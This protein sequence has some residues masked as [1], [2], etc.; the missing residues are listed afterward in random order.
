MFTRSNKA[1]LPL[2]AKLGYGTIGLANI[3]NSMIGTW[4]LFFFTTFAGMDVALAGMTVAGGQIAAALV[5]PAWGYLSDRLY[6]MRIGRAIGRR[7]AT[8]L[9]TAP[10]LFAFSIL[11]FAHGL[12]VGVYIASNFLYW[13]F[14]AGFTTVQYIMPSEMTGDLG[15][16]AQLVGINQIA[17]AIAAIT[18]S[19]VNTFLF[20]VWGDTRWDTYFRLSVVYGFAMLAIMVVGLFTIR[21]RP[22]DSMTDFSDVDATDNVAGGSQGRPGLIERAKLMAWNY[23]SAFSVREFRRY[24]G[25]YL[26]QF[27][28]RTIRGSTLTY[29]LV[30]VLG[31]RASEVSLSQGFSFAF[32]IC[33]VGFFM[34]V[35]TKIGAVRAYRVSCVE[36]MAVFIVLYVLAQIHGQLGHGFT[37]AA[38]I[39]LA[40]ALNIGVT[41]VVNATDLA[42]ASIP[43]VD[44]IL[45]GKRREGQ[46]ASINSTIGG[47]FNALSSVVITGILAASGFVAGATEQPRHVVELLTD[48]FCLVPIVF[49]LVGI[50]FSFRVRL[51]EGNRHVLIAEIERLRADGRK[52]DVDPAT[53]GFIED[54]TGFPYEQCWGENR[55]VNYARRAIGKE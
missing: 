34:W 32:G 19:T 5:A 13:S 22:I 52:E 43:D 55:V 33:L 25:M 15:D 27:L 53:R 51:N 28:F 11:Q 29:F 24:L 45:T 8:L 54:L 14:H 35:N 47:L 10:G 39:A 38:W 30:F 21:E 46:F 7:K 4:Q 49:C 3:S 41:G 40:L 23:V 44:E 42:Y 16:R 20:A 9:M 12:P 48:V 50:F 18:F 37:V 26:S 6:G 2:R 36:A 31:L 1:A 17:S